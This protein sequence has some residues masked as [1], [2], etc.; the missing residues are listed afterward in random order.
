MAK[1]EW[2]ERVLAKVTREALTAVRLRAQR[3]R[4][5]NRMTELIKRLKSR[6]C[7]DCHREYPFYVMDF[8]HR[9]PSIR[10]FGMA[11][12]RWRTAKVI[13]AEAR[14]CDVVCANCHRIRTYNQKHQLQVH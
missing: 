12:G 14:K 4:K 13:E 6:P 10:R 11:K 8:D 2:A 1:D 9:D 7:A 5:Y 3:R